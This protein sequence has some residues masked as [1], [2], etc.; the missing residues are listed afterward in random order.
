MERKNIAIIGL[1][2]VILLMGI[3][4]AAFSKL[5]NING[6][7][8]ISANWDVRISNITEGSLVGATPK[9]AAIVGNDNL[10]ATFDIDLKYPGASATYIVTIQNAG[11]I[12]AI[13]E[14]VSGVDTANS[15]EPTDLIYSINATE[16]D[17]LASGT[18]KDYSVTVQ[19]KENGTQVPNVQSKSATITLNYLQNT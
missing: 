6:T 7:A 12:D 18:S 17:L 5:L 11:T 13:L 4:Y 1:I 16:G 10:S 8:N 9:T 2:V 14:T 15:A 3:G 19:W